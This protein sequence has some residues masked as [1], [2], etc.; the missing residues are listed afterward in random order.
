[1]KQAIPPQVLFHGIAT[2]VLESILKTGIKKKGRQY[3]HLSNNKETATKV[4][5][6]LQTG[7]IPRTF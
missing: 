7:I 5:A 4:G 6:R 3:V 1:M 2:R